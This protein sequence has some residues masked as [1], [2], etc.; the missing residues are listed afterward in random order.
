MLVGVNVE[1]VHVR[2][3]V[4]FVCG[5]DVD[6]GVRSMSV[7]ATEDVVVDVVVCKSGNVLFCVGEMYVGVDPREDERELVVAGKKQYCGETEL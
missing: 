6:V 5:K 4:E 2:V 1:V 3:G 7:I